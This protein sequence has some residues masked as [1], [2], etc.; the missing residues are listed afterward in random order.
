MQ[1]VNQADVPKI[2]LVAPTNRAV[3]VLEERLQEGIPVWD[4]T[5]QTWTH[6][7]PIYRRL[8]NEEID[9]NERVTHRCNE[10][11]PNYCHAYRGGLTLCTPGSVYRAFPFRRDMRSWRAMEHYQYVIVDEASQL[12]DSEL[13]ILMNILA[14]SSNPYDTS[15]PRMCYVGDPYQ[16]PPNTF[17]NRP[18]CYF[19]TKQLSF[20]ERMI[21]ECSPFL[22]GQNKIPAVHLNIQ[23]R[24]L[25]GICDLADLISMR[26]VRKI[27][28]PPN[29]E[30]LIRREDETSR[31]PFV[32]NV[33][34]TDI[35]IADLL[36]H[37]VC[38]DPYVDASNVNSHPADDIIQRANDP[39]V[40]CSPVEMVEVHAVLPSY[41]NEM[42][43][44]LVLNNMRILSPYHRQCEMMK[45]LLNYMFFGTQRP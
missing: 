4:M 32:Y 38:I 21:P 13:F 42:E 45:A 9:R 43:D 2:L 22:S 35:T 16:L 20:L 10:I 34:V 29:W 8:G 40:E 11:M 12:S 17:C 27:I 36:N 41:Y 15:W 6:I 26:L 25:P 19:Y 24:M 31:P 28:M 7:I 3:D 33:I 30:Q 44:H 18:P 37:I 1:N 14:C 5:L 23:Y 39:W